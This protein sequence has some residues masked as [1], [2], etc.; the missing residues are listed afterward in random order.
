MLTLIDGTDRQYSVNTDNLMYVPMEED[1]F[2]Q[3]VNPGVTKSGMAIFSIA[4]DANEFAMF[5]SEGMFGTN[6]GGFY[7]GK[8]Q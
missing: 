4:P 7:F 8:L 6:Q 2:F 3:Q 1:I 5:V